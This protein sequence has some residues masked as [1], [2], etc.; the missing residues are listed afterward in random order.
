[1]DNP[2]IDAAELFAMSVLLGVDMTPNNDLDVRLDSY[3]AGINSC[4]DVL[5]VIEHNTKTYESS[6]VGLEPS[7]QS[8]DNA[9]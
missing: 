4:L 3:I 7:N 6:V 8:L 5:T 2:N 1:M 9:Q